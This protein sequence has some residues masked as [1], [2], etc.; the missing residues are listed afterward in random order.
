MLRRRLLANKDVDTRE[1]DNL[2]AFKSSTNPAASQ[3]TEDGLDFDEEEI[4]EMLEK[5]TPRA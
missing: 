4:I 2:K 3:F 1:L 5:T